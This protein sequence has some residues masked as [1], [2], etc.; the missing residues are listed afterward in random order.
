MRV[1]A[2]DAGT[3]SIKAVL[4]NIEEATGAATVELSHVEPLP[5]PLNS[6]MDASIWWSAALTAID[7]VLMRPAAKGEVVDC[8]TLSGQMQSTLLIQQDGTPLRNALIYSDTRATAEAAQIEEAIGRERL[9]SE[10]TNWKGAASTLA[11]LVWLLAHEADAVDQCAAVCLSAHEYLFFRLTGGRAMTDATN[12]SVTGLLQKDAAELGWARALLRDAGL[13]QALVDKLPAVGSGPDLLA[14]LSTSAAAS[15][16]STEAVSVGT[17]RI[18]LGSGDLGSTTVG[19][20]G[21]ALLS[22]SMPSPSSPPS[23]PHADTYCYLGTSGWVATVRSETDAAN[24]DAFSVRHPTAASMRILAAPMTTAGGNVRWLCRLL[25]P[26]LPDNEALAAFEAEAAA[27]TPTCDGLLYLP[28]LQGE[29]CPVNDPN[30]RACFVGLGPD[31]TRAH[32]CRAVLEGICFAVRSL[33]S[34]LPAEAATCTPHHLLTSN[35]AGAIAAARDKKAAHFS[36]PESLVAVTLPPLV[37]VGGVASS[38]VLATTLAAVLQREIRVSNSPSHV[39]AL[40][41]AAIALAALAEQDHPGTAAGTAPTPPTSSPTFESYQPNANLERAYNAAYKRFCTLHPS[42]S[43]T[44][45]AHRR[46][47]DADG[48]ERH[49]S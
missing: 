32:M 27:A 15:L 2:L 30:A 40:G 6:E 38:K 47:R 18:C 24:C 44:F 43:E 17:T 42:L 49:E 26:G 23:L 45:S 10:V 22:S 28:Y 35:L 33:L 20:L 12:A 13:P 37:L 4:A 14:P 21:A 3:S 29:R 31:T 7:C 39:P 11:K 8:I 16:S 5:P 48:D 46:A 19:A 34:L 41:A 1:L 36:F 25:Y 9:L